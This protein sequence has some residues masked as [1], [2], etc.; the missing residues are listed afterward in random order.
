MKLYFRIVLPFLLAVGPTTLVSAEIMIRFIFNDGRAPSIFEGTYCSSTENSLINT[1]FDLKNLLGRRHR[2]LRSTSGTNSTSSAVTLTPHTDT[3]E[4]AYPRKCKDNCAGL[5]TGTCRAT[6]CVGYRRR[7]LM[8]EIDGKGPDER[9]LVEQCP[10]LVELVHT[11]LDALSISS[12]CRK[13]LD[14]SKRS[15]TCLDD[16]IY[17]EIEGVRLWKVSL[18]WSTVLQDRMPS[19]GYS[20]CRG[21]SFNLE[22]INNDCVEN[23][24]MVLKGPNNY[25]YTNLQTNAP[26][27]LFNDLGITMLGQKVPTAGEYTL[28]ITPDGLD[29]KKKTFTFTVKNC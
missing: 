18:L 8:D 9:S 4:L 12:T 6:D 29:Y 17:G 22:S 7:E 1:I 15:T 25:E 21:T 20:F 13:F 14:K 26:Y 2:Q 10:A 11:K 5:A 24:L 3:R 19:S 16:I 28:S 27:T 23:A